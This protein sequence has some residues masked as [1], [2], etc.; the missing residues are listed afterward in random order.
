MRNSIRTF[1]ILG[2]W[3]LLSIP[4]VAWTQH[5][6]PT[7]L[8][9][10]SLQG[11]VLDESSHEPIQSA[12]V[13]I[14]GSDLET[15]TDAYGS[16]SVSNPPS[17]PVNVRVAAPGFITIVEEVEVVAGAIVHLQVFLPPLA[18]L[19][20]EILV[21]SPA[22]AAAS[23]RSATAADLVARQVPGLL[24][25][26]SGPGDTDRG[27][28]LRG[29]S[30]FTQGGDPHLLIDGVRVVGTSAIYEILNQIPAEDVERVEVLR[31]P[32]AAFLH[33]YAANGVIH[34]HTKTGRGGQR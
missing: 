1:V 19:L 32:A 34:V 33:P 24:F 23:D 2:A 26:Q 20:S 13:T 6:L 17:G 9:L 22:G 25:P 7:P 15:R 5:G 16:F 31:G 14:V 11:I 30:T 8:D 29:I 18:A 21:R 12:T 10:R 28:R 4:S 3:G 27:I